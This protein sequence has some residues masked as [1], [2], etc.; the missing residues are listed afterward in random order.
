MIFQRTPILM[1]LL[2]INKLSKVGYVSQIANFPPRE[3]CTYWCIVK[4]GRRPNGKAK[5][6]SPTVAA[7]RNTVINHEGLDEWKRPSFL[8]PS[9]DHRRGIPSRNSRHSSHF[10]TVTGCI[11]DSELS[12]MIPF[13]PFAP[14]ITMERH[15]SPTRSDA[16][17]QVYSH[18]VYRRVAPHSYL[19]RWNSEYSI[20][21]GS[22]LD[23]I[24]FRHAWFVTVTITCTQV[25]ND[26]VNL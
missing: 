5:L 23:E 2:T 8:C 22:S 16:R 10:S 3:V 4:S 25:A 20:C 11:H 24:M 15:S 19:G 26:A 7:S 9:L 18:S 12:S 21:P 17:K 6:K 14:C 13:L 1:S